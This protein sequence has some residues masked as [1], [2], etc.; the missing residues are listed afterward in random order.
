L[1]ATTND[2]ETPMMSGPWGWGLG[3]LL[4]LALIVIGIVLLVRGPSR[5]TPDQREDSSLRILEERFARGEIDEEE[6]R[7]RRRTLEGS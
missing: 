6:Y 2:K 5:S 3:S 1:S 4:F 7:H